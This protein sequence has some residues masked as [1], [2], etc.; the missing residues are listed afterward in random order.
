[1]HF[2]KS[3]LS[4]INRFD[5]S[6]R[7][8]SFFPNQLVRL[9]MTLIIFP[10]AFW[11]DIPNSWIFDNPTLATENGRVLVVPLNNGLV[12]LQSFEGLDSNGRVN[13]L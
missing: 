3:V 1:M 10:L 2:G 5:T 7:L 6:S 13:V 11:N 8:Q 9:G 12:W 4:E